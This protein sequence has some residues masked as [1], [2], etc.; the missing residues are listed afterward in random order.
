MREPGRFAD[1]YQRQA[2]VGDPSG[3]RRPSEASRSL[4]SPRCGKP[5]LGWW[6]TARR[7]GGTAVGVVELRAQHGLLGSSPRR[8]S[9]RCSARPAGARQHR[10]APGAVAPSRG[11]LDEAWPKRRNRSGGRRRVVVL[12]RSRSPP[13]LGARRRGARESATGT[14]TWR[15]VRFVMVVAS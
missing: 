6:C 5:R 9:P 12:R 3:T 1:R 8:S 14:S 11:V 10:L 2:P 15:T 13:G 4:A 7:R